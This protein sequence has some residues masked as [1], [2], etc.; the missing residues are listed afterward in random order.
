MAE[1][2]GMVEDGLLEEED[3]AEEVLLLTSGR[4]HSGRNSKRPS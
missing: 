4:A 3:I 2:R 1:L